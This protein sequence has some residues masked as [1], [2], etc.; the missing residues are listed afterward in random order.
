VEF[1]FRSDDG[2]ESFWFPAAQAAQQFAQQTER[3]YLG[4]A[5]EV[6]H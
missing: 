4:Q 2:I 1:A 3:E 6:L 5:L